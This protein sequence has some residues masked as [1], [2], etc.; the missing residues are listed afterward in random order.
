MHILLELWG[1]LAHYSLLLPC[2]WPNALNPIR[3]L[4]SRLK[5][6]LFLSDFTKMAR[7]VTPYMSFLCVLLR[8]GRDGVTSWIMNYSDIS[9]TFTD[10]HK[11]KNDRKNLSV[12][13]NAFRWR[14]DFSTSSAFGGL[15][16]KWQWRVFIRG[17]SKNLLDGEDVVLYN[18][19]HT[20]E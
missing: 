2:F 9:R 7:Y 8:R 4:M 19:Y 1:H 13:R 15:R 3:I 6:Y 16:S 18:I 5:Y 12:P 20:Y 17:F 11:G 14:P 10:L